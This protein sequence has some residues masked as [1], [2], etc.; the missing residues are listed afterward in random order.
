M[1]DIELS[2]SQ[3]DQ[4]YH[5]FQAIRLIFERGI[6]EP[7][8]RHRQV[9]KKIISSLNYC[10]PTLESESWWEPTLHFFLDKQQTNR[11]IALA[12]NTE[13]DAIY[14]LFPQISSEH[15]DSDQTLVSAEI[16]ALRA[17]LFLN[18]LKHQPPWPSLN[19]LVQLDPGLIYQ[20]SQFPPENQTREYK[21]TFRWDSTSKQKNSNQTL[22]NWMVTVS[23]RKVR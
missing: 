14:A 11:L 17:K 23:W 21:S 12:K 16:N 3:E 7:S 6:H 22:I 5:F 2:L 9:A 15:F 18:A 20:Q 8:E 1:D 10:G 13:R 19:T 4:S